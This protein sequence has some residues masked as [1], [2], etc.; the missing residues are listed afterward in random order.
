MDQLHGLGICRPAILA[1]TVFRH[2]KPCMI[3]ALPMQHEAQ[4][5][6]RDRDDDLLDD[7]P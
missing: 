5:I 2:F 6:D 7:G 1:S 3:T 4:S